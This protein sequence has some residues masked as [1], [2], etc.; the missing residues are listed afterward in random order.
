MRHN[1]FTKRFGY[2][3]GAQLEALGWANS[4]AM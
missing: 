3:H 1:Y 2:L 4:I